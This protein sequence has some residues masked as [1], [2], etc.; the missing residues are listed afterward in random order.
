MLSENLDCTVYHYHFKPPCVEAELSLFITDKQFQTLLH[1]P[2]L[3]PHVEIR[4]GKQ[5]HCCCGNVF[6]L[7]FLTVD[8]K[9]FP[10]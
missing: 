1:N 5:Q 2:E 9:D 6:V 10:A 7:L 8:Y 4:D 3:F